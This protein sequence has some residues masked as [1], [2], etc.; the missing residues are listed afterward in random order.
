MIDANVIY[1]QVKQT[2]LNA[3]RDM[4]QEYYNKY[5]NPNN[6]PLPNEL[7]DVTEQEIK[8]LVQDILT[9]I[10]TGL[11]Q[12]VLTASNSAVTMDGGR[13]ALTVLASLISTWNTTIT[14]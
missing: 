8:A 2:V 7:N 4:M 1:Q 13:T 9:G 11:A 12:D 5:G 10:K 3:L 14:E 6:D